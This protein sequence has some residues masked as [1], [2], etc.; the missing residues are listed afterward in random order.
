MKLNKFISFQIR[1]QM[2][3]W[4][5]LFPILLIL[6]LA[7]R[8]YNHLV[9]VGANTPAN[10]WDLLFVVFGNHYNIYFGI[11]LLF[12]YLVSDL[13][14][15][16]NIGQLVLLRLKS[17]RQW[18]LGKVIS[19]IVLTLIYQL[20]LLAIL[21]LI[22]VIVLPVERGYSQ[23]AQSSPG[24][25]NLS[26]PGRD[27]DLLGANGTPLQYL[28]TNLGLLALGLICFGLIMMAAVQLGGKYYYGLLAGLVLVFGSFVSTML[29]GPPAWAKWLPGWH[30]TYITVMPVRTIPLGFSFF[31]WLVLFIFFYLLGSR[32]AS[33]QDYSVVEE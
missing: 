19:L 29:S 27:G 15:E 6:F 33:H 5:W 16:S 24:L 22:A 1:T 9:F 8:S 30:L 25:V 21:S 20:L 23:L 11:A 10:A 18:W 32:I 12:V 17:R 13:L 3:R 2:K 31:Y 14:P 7:Y 26:L 4:R 28:L